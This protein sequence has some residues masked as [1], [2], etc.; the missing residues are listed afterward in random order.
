MGVD[1]HRGEDVG[2]RGGDRGGLL[3]GRRPA[4]HADANE[5]SH[6]GLPGARQHPGT[7]FTEVRSI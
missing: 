3:G 6:A 7:F 1:A 5:S 2:L 4:P